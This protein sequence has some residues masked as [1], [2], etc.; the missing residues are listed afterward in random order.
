MT[1]GTQRSISTTAPVS[2]DR[3][4]PRLALLIV[5]DGEFLYYARQWRTLRKYRA[6]LREMARQY[7]VFVDFKEVR[8]VLDCPEDVDR[9]TNDLRGKLTQCW[10]GGT[11]NGSGAR[12]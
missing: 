12:R 1:P 9:L 3:L 6:R 2:S 11:E 4:T 10:I 5:T 7:P 8:V